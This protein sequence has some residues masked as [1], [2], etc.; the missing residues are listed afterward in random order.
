MAAPK[1]KWKSKPKRPGAS[2]RWTNVKLARRYRTTSTYDRTEPEN[3][4]LKHYKIVRYFMKRQ[5]NISGEDLDMLQYLYAEPLFTR[6]QFLRR[7]NIF[8]WDKERFDRLLRD[9]WI[10]IWRQRSSGESNLYEATYKAKRMIAS[11][12]Q[13]LN[14]EKPIPATERRNVVLRNTGTFT[15][16]VYALA[17]HEFNDEIIKSKLRH[18]SE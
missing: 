5:Y 3:N 16:K 8:S 1:K 14:G 17:I 10:H 7:E 11:M 13:M 15:D 6:S 18:A 2:T 9:G 12:Y 4:Y